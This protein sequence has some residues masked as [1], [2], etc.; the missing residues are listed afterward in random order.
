MRASLKKQHQSMVNLKFSVKPVNT[1][2]WIKYTASILRTCMRLTAAQTQLIHDRWVP[3]IFHISPT[4]QI[5]LSRGLNELDN[6]H[7]NT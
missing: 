7:D 2:T 1:R 6:V 3:R 5:P 4:N